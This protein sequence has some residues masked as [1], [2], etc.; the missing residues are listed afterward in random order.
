LGLILPLPSA[1]FCLRAFADRP[2]LKDARWFNIAALAW[3]AAQIAAL[4]A[5][6]AQVS[7]ANRYHDMLLLGLTIHFVSALWIVQAQ[8]LGAQRRMAASLALAAWIA[9]TAVSLSRA[10]RHLPRQID[11]W[12]EVIETG[13]KNVRGY[14][15]TGDA[16]FLSG[17][18]VFT[19]P[20]VT[21]SRLRDYLET[22]EARS[23]LPP[24]L[25]SREPP[26]NRVE[27]FKRRFLRFAPGLIG[28]GVVILPVAVALSQDQRERPRSGLEAEG[29]TWRRSQQTRA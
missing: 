1:L 27:A 10:E 17:P 20:Y 21:A 7:F 9:T 15:A 26:H 4:A 5:G 18:P 2:E 29:S 16:R 6:R 25:A 12:R 14:L 11:E 24:E 8:P 19:L 22:P 28:L 3:V 13:G 23:A